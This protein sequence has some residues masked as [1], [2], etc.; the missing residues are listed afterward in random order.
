MN[1]IF[2]LSS[3]A[4]QGT[5]VYAGSKQSGIYLSSNN[6]ASWD[7]VNTGLTT[8]FITSLAVIGSTVFA[9]TD[10]GGVFQSS[11]SGASWGQVN[12]GLTS[13][14]VNSFA[15]NGTNI[16]AGSYTDGVFLST[17]NGA[18]WTPVNNG[19]SS[20]KVFS[21]SAY[22]NTILALSDSGGFLSNNNGANW[23][24]IDHTGITNNSYI[25][26]MTLNDSFIFAATDPPITNLWRRPISDI[27]SINKASINNSSISIYPNPA[28]D[29]INIE[30]TLAAPER[31]NISISDM[32]GK[33][34]NL[35]Y[36]ERS[37]LG[38]NKIKL[39]IN[40]LKQGIYFVNVSIGKYREQKKLVVI[41]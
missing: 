41:K 17:N 37:K 13:L 33:N 22:N 1:H 32:L 21:L 3:I 24:A 18:S 34:Y 40:S 27:L 30:Y 11:N 28:K 16:F 9:G 20:T 4:I 12:N 5:K 14:S 10:G 29:Y 19:L 35:L 6:G 36:S 7:S 15:V 23:T 2:F 25:G 8:R 31:V 38:N 39:D 26:G